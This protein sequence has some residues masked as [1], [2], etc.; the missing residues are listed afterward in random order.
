MGK[1]IDANHSVTV[2]CTYYISFLVSLVG[3]EWNRSN[4]HVEVN[5]SAISI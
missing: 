3:I 5:S 4:L 2:I 1:T